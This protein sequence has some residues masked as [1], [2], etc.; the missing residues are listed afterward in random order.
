MKKAYNVKARKDARL[1]IHIQ[2]ELLE[3]ARAAAEAAGMTLSEAVRY[4]LLDFVR[5]DIKDIAANAHFCMHQVPGVPVG[6]CSTDA[7][8]NDEELRAVADEV[9]RR[10][11]ERARPEI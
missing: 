9:M 6:L 2:P 5:R 10:L 7:P 1:H 11:N 8:L 4:L 3:R